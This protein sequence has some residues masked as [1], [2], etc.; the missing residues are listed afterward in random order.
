MGEAL[1]ARLETGDQGTFGVLRAGDYQC[2]TVELPWRDNARR[3]SHI[4]AGSYP[5]NLILAG[6]FGYVYW[7]QRVPGRSEI[8]I[9]TGAWAG[10][11]TKG[12]RTHSAGCI[13]LGEKRG[14]AQDQKCVLI[15]RPAISR[16]RDAFDGKPFT[17]TIE[18]HYGNP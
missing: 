1:I 11:T 3:V 2:H 8:L 16:L 9:H 5:C 12:Y 13:L 14:V 17:L 7:V 6:K 4:P 15:S 18:D 10:D